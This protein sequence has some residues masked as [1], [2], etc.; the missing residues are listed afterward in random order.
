[1]ASNTVYVI[2][3]G[4]RG[5]GLGLVKALLA[6][7]ATTVVATVRSEQAAAVLKDETTN[8]AKGDGSA[9]HAV[10]LDFSTAVAPEQ[11]RQTVTAAGVD[12]VDV[13]IN[14]AGGA[15]PMVPAL[16]TTAED[17][18]AAFETNTIAP[19]LVFQG[20]WPLLQ[21]SAAPK[22]F[23]MS[24]SV[25]SISEMEPVPGGAYGPSRCA[26][27]WLT[28]AIHVENKDSGLVAVA[29][30]P[31]WVQTRAG[32]FVADEWGFSKGPPDSVESSVEGMLKVIDGATKETSGTFTTSKGDTLGW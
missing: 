31:G 6:R 13:L 7:P 30:H 29:L 25:G 12:K 27:N 17:L 2:T 8:T 24:S 3:G 26:Q 9:L 4:N 21:R 16:E 1:M 19:L 32:Q 15:Q 14:N 18:R 10:L 28:R 5:L 20:L 11:V 23:M 22:L